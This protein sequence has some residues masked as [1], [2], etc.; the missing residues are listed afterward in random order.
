MPIHA[1]SC[2]APD[3]PTDFVGVDT[4]PITVLQHRD[5]AGIDDRAGMDRPRPDVKGPRE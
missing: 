1:A 5:V 3:I 4:A 2:R